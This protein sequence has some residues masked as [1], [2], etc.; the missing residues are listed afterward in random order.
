MPGK[1]IPTS[2]RRF[3]PAPRSLADRFWEKVDRSAG[4]EGCWVWTAATNPRGYGVIGVSVP[5][6]AS[7]LASRVSWELNVGPI[8]EGMHVL[9]NC[10]GADNPAC[11]NPAHLWLGTQADNSRD[12]SNKGQIRCGDARSDTCLTGEQV[13]EIRARGINAAEAAREYSVSQTTAYRV[14]H[15]RTWKHLD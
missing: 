3:G 5:K 15:R 12:A 9:H 4:P 14:I 1:S 10:P 2:R 7:M 11:V 8:P 13:R 6:R